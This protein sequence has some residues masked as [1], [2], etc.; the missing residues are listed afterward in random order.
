MLLEEVRKNFH[1]T[2]IRAFDEK[3]M[4]ND[5]NISK[6]YKDIKKTIISQD[7]QIM[8]ILTSL[9]KNKR[10]IDSTM[11]SEDMIRKLKENILIAGPTGT[12]KTEI[13]TKI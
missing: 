9:F 2:K 3:N 1:V 6:L 11:L 5:S 8:M 10:V 12:G 4:D 13:L 7:E